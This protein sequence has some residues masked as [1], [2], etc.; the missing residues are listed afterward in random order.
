[1][2]D[3]QPKTRVLIVDDDQTLCDMY[4]E[5]LKAEGYDV[6]VA[7]N[8]E[9]G[10]AKAVEYLP[11]VILLDLM[12][13]KVNG[14][15]TLE[16]LKSTEETKN[17]PV[18]LLTALIQEENKRRGIQAG[19]EDYII[20]SETMPGAVIEKIK[21]AVEK[22]KRMQQAGTKV[23]NNSPDQMTPPPV[24]P[25]PTPAPEVA[26]TPQPE[27]VPPLAP[28]VTPESMAQRPPVASPPAEPPAPVDGSQS[29][30]PPAPPQPAE[31]APREELQTS[32][33][34][35]SPEEPLTPPDS[36]S[37]PSSSPP[38]STGAMPP[39]PPPPPQQ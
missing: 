18:L 6:A 26:P 27:T 21:A 5:R 10:A 24:S 7:H 11:H 13:P 35:K 19:A 15:N 30:T 16:I 31:P 29:V 9:E 39:V 32:F 14:F 36:S 8:G 22:G 3:S 33:P 1:M 28:P 34:P 25:E 38:P 2:E 20:K 17:I 23:D 37:T 12:M 4:A